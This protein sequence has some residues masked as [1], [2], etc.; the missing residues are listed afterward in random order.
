MFPGEDKPQNTAE[1]ALDAK[2]REIKERNAKREAR[3]K[4]IEREKKL[5]GGR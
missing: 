3:Q 2:I 1:A 5:F 4:E